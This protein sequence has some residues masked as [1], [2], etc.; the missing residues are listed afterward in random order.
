MC[1]NAERHGLT[2]HSR[3][4][5]FFSFFFDEEEGNIGHGLNRVSGRMER[6]LSYRNPLRFRLGHPVNPLASGPDTITYARSNRRWREIYT[7]RLVNRALD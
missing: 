5:F 2:T 6:V 3:L 7:A 1:G 4:L